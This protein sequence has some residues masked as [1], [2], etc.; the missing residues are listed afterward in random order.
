MT[1]KQ[2][3]KAEQDAFFD[4]LVKTQIEWAASVLGELLVHQTHGHRRE[5][6]LDGKCVCRWCVCHRM[7]HDHE[8]RNPAAAERNAEAAAK[9]GGAGL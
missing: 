7:V 1:F 2:V 9:K 4:K 3:T 5:K 6:A 8:Q